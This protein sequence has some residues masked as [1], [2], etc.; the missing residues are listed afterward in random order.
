L[1]SALSASLSPNLLHL[2]GET[3]DVYQGALGFP[4]VPF[5]GIIFVFMCAMFQRLM[6]GVGQT[7]ILLY[8]VAGTSR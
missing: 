5:V 7:R 6:R 2:H 8:I 1:C 3:P 4:R